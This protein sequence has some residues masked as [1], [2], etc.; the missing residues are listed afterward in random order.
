VT[1]SDCISVSPDKKISTLYGEGEDRIGVS[2][3]LVVVLNTVCSV[4]YNT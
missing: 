3:W 1:R 2:Q 4:P